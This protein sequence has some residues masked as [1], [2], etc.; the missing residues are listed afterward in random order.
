MDSDLLNVARRPPVDPYAVAAFS[1]AVAAAVTRFTPTLYN[2]HY[3]FAFLAAVI[4]S[5]WYGGIWPSLLAMALSSLCFTYLVA[6]PPGTTGVAPEDKTRLLRFVFLSLLASFFQGSLRKAEQASRSVCQRLS[7]ALDATGMG[8]WDLDLVTGVLWSSPNLARIFGR[9]AATFPR[10]YE[11]FLEYVHPDDREF[12]DQSVTRARQAGIEYHVQ[13][14]IVVDGGGIRWVA[15]RG[16]AVV[17]GRGKPTR[18]IAVVEDVTQQPGTIRPPAAAPERVVVVPSGTY[19]G[20]A[21]ADDRDLTGDV[22]IVL[23]VREDAGGKP[24][25]GGS[26]VLPP[27]ADVPEGAYTLKLSDGRRGAVRVNRVHAVSDRVKTASFI[28]DGPLA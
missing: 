3:L 8:V 12:V 4:V 10:A 24:H 19:V 23:D 16:R 27:G 26:F 21:W 18:L 11:A 15:M 13:H 7:F 14:R 5:A 2:Q 28:G 20:R 9:P 22:E 6:S 17:D 1:V 25:W